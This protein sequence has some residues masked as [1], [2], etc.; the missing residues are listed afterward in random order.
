[1][2]WWIIRILVYVWNKWCVYLCD[3]DTKEYILV[4]L[5]N[6]V[7]RAP[8]SAVGLSCLHHLATICMVCR[9]SKGSYVKDYL[10]IFCVYVFRRFHPHLRRGD[11]P[12]AHNWSPWFL[13]RLWGGGGRGRG[14]IFHGILLAC[15][16]QIWVLCTL[17]VMISL[18]MFSYFHPVL[19]RAVLPVALDGSPQFLPCLWRV[20]KPG[21]VVYYFYICVFWCWFYLENW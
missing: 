19:G 6:T 21:S 14:G 5:G 4:G 20:M 18:C 11:T 16:L 13:L 12:G 3:G 15:S 8:S 10:V 17:Y 9:S 7:K 1:M 2:Y